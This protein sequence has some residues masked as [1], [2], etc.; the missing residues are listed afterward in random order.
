MTDEPRVDSEADATPSPSNDP[1]MRPRDPTL[2][3]DAVLVLDDITRRRK[4]FR[5]SQA[6]HPAPLP[7]H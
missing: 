7:R 4:A 2:A 5:N 6:D 1:K 3:G